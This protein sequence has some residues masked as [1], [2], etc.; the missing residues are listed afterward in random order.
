M[1]DV[2]LIIPEGTFL[3]PK[4]STD[5]A[6]CPAVVGGNTEVSQRLVDTLLKAFA[7]SACSQGTM[8]NFLFGTN[9]FGYYETICGG[10]GA[11]LGFN[12]SSAVH[13]H[14]TNTQIT[15]PEILEFRYPVKLEMFKIRPESGG[16]GEW[17]GGNGVLRQFKFIE[18]V[19]ITFLTQHRKIAPYGMAGGDS[20]ACGEQFL[21]D[22]YG[23]VTA[24]EGVG[25]YKIQQNQRIL[26]ATPG[27]GG[28]GRK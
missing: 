6:K 7:L 5:P 10:T 16:N 27:G 24:L 12:G 18:P 3:N 14:M 26:I 2:E 23:K 9:D 1:R 15:D 22:E 21:L 4:F 25:T 11:G 20:G 28:Y 19:T 13:Q 17:K 8:N